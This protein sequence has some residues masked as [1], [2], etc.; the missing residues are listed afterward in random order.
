MWKKIVL[1]AKMNTAQSVER[2]V[3]FSFAELKGQE[4]KV[5]LC[6]HLQSY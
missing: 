4:A 3:V 1:Y 2:F 6:S 5:L